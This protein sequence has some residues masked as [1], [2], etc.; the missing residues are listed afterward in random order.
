MIILSGLIAMVKF[1]L[2]EDRKQSKLH[3]Q[4][5]IPYFLGHAAFAHLFNMNFS[6]ISLYYAFV[7]AFAASNKIYSK[8]LKINSIKKREATCKDF[9]EY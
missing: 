2:G 9:E 4:T 5:V 1:P 7:F 8:K 3:F 6:L